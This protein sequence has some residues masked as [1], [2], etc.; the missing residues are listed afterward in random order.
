MSRRMSSIDFITYSAR[1][2]MCL[3]YSSLCGYVI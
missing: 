1:T 3:P 2:S